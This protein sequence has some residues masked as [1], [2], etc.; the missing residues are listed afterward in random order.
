MKKEEKTE[1]VE[2]LIESFSQNKSLYF[3]DVSDLTVDQTTELRK[4][5]YKHGIKLRVSKNTFI[6]KALERVNIH[7]EELINALKGPSSI[8]YSDTINGAAKLIKEFRRTHTKPLL[9]AAYI[10]DI[11]Y[12]GDKN[13]DALANLKSKNELIADLVMLLNSPMM[14]LI[15]ALNS[16]GNKIAG[17][18]ETLGNKE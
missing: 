15:N 12:V 14:N 6:R 17:I 2:Q 10:D 18:L 9:K 16:G 8:M 1:I 13:L 7:D 11:V 3:T 4:L 5:C